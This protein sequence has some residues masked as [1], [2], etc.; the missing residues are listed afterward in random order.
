MMEPNYSLACKMARKILKDYKLN[1]VPTDLKKI[2]KDIKIDFIEIYEPDG[3]DGAIIEMKDKTK[4]AFLNTAKPVAR[5][6]FTLAHELGHIF[7]KHDQRSIQELKMISIDTDENDLDFSDQK[8]PSI[9]TEADKFASELLIPFAQLKKHKA[10]LKN[11]D[12]LAN[13]FQVSK[14]AMSMAIANNLRYL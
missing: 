10:E 14:A 8:K 7:L 4:I 12:S 6:R 1:T 9:E 13:V 11:L 2:F 5:Q 3:I